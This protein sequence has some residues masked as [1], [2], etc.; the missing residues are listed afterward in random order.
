[1]KILYHHRTSARDGSAVHID[2]LVTA[3]RAAGAEV[4][5]VA[6]AGAA[7]RVAVDARNSWLHYVRKKLPGFA[8]ELGEAVYN[9]PESARLWR[10]V[11]DF[12]P[13]VIYQRSNLYLVSGAIVARRANLPLIEEVNAPYFLER[14]RHGGLSMR[15]L[16]SWTERRAW[17]SADAVIAVTQ[18]LASIVVDTGVPRERLHVMP[19]GIDASLLQPQAV[20]PAAKQRL[21]LGNYLVLGF[22]GFVRDWNGLDTVLELLATP[23]GRQ[24]FLLVVGDGPARPALEARARELGVADRLRFTGVVARSAVPGLVSAFDI[25]L[26]PAANPYASP[27]KLFEYMALARA[28]VAPD[29]ANLREVLTNDQDAVLFDPRSPAAFGHT[30][31]R[32]AADAGLRTRIAANAAAAVHRRD[33]T[34]RRNA[35]RVL[36]LARSLTAGRS[37]R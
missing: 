19:N 37:V 6:P 1:M 15:R 21:G 12:R 33:L 2:G 14:G 31:K 35:E 11:Q 4:K 7:P 9:L 23:E 29:Q 32:L 8:H 34:W 3:L 24:W 18:V 25:A 36:E 26:Q 5:V 28:I 10:A 17:T 13:D 16:A 27:L 30:L 22:T 20:D